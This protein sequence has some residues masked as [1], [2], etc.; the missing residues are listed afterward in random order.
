MGVLCRTVWRMGL[1]LLH[2]GRLQFLLRFQY[3]VPIRTRIYS[4]LCLYTC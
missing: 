1:V 4:E 2:N 3:G